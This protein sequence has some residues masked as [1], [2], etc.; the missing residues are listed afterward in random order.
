MRNMWIGA[1]VQESWNWSCDCESIGEHYVKVHNIDADRES[2]KDYLHY[3]MDGNVADFIPLNCNCSEIYYLT[4]KSLAIHQLREG[5]DIVTTNQSGGARVS[6]FDD[7]PTLSHRR[8][9]KVVSDAEMDDYYTFTTEESN[10]ES[11]KMYDFKYERKIETLSVE[12]AVLP[13]LSFL[14]HAV[15]NIRKFVHA[16]NF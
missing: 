8:R 4:P 2:L 15:E 12:D 16:N 11:V 1:V 3:L 6:F 5:C 9:Q 13:P 7:A 10:V 14:E